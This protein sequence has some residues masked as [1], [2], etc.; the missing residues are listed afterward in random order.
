MVNKVSTGQ[1][2][3]AVKKPIDGIP[4]LMDGQNDC[5]ST[6]GHPKDTK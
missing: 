3:Q 5:S 1:Q 4:G 6:I 2:C